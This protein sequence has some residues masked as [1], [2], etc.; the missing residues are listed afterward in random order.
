MSDPKDE[1]VEAEEIEEEV[2]PD[3]PAPGP[4]ER[5]SPSERQD[6][7]DAGRGHLLGGW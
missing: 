7:R 5:Y 3:P 2:E 4:R 6:I 1:P